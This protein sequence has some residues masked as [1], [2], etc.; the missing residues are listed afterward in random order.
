MPATVNANMLT[1]V[2]A[3]SNGISTWFPDVCK[4]P[5]PGG[6]IPIPYPNIA[7]SS[8]TADGSSTVKVD[9]NPVMLKGSNFKMSTGDEAGSAMGVVSNKIK[10]KAEPVNYSFDVK[11]DGKNAFR[12]TDMMTQ[13]A[14]SNPNGGPGTDVQ[15]P[16]P[17]IPTDGPEC[18]RTHAEKAAQE[19]SSTSWGESGVIGR[20][21]PKIQAVATEEK[22]VIYIRQTK[23]ICSPFITASH[24]PKPHSCISGTTIKGE[25]KGKVQAWLDDYFKGLNEAERAVYPEFANPMST[26]RFYNSKA[27]AYVGIIGVP[28]G[29]G[30]I[31]PKKGG[32]RQTVSYTG[33]WMTGDY[34]LFEIVG[35]GDQCTKVT[36][37]WFA[38]IKKEIN[39]RCRWDAIQ[40]PAQAQWVPSKK[41][42]KIKGQRKF[43]MNVLVSSVLSG[44]LKVDHA[45]TFHADRKPMSV[46]DK[47]LTV[48]AGSGVVTLKEQNNVKDALVCQGCAK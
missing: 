24:Q 7:M 39:K 28:A 1:L 41:E 30:K 21:K 29:E 17:A 19:S 13:N 40:H 36:G 16:K 23:A 25:D 48:V 26:N 22:V 9:G 11:I 10:G 43:N 44:K 2:H 12:L 20:H 5:T 3:S 34:D 38:K 37:D 4:T 31:Q 46:L 27:Q 35:A 47:P 32:G 6:P 8:D 45:I 42:L 18:E 33:K 15:P 14:G